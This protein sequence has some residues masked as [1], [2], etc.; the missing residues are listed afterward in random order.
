[1]SNR[2][3]IEKVRIESNIKMYGELSKE[4]KGHVVEFP[5]RFLEKEQV[6]CLITEKEYFM[7]TECLT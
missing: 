5:L 1:M 4:I 3:T 2:E 7:P 6:N